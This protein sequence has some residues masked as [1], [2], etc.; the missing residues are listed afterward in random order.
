MITTQTTAT[1]GQTVIY[2][3]SM[4]DFRGPAVFL[5]PCNVDGDCRDCQDQFDLWEFHGCPGDAPI[6]YR[7][8]LAGG[9]ELA[10]VRAES[11]T[12]HTTETITADEDGLFEQIDAEGTQRCTVCGAVDSVRTEEYP[13]MYAGTER[14]ETC[15][16]CGSWEGSGD[17]FKGT[18]RIQRRH[19]IT[20]AG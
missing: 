19:R 5:G 4:T 16:G 18:R 8:R 9:F 6:R 10:C 14:T 15:D 17:P 12:A 3:G 13:S 2:H 7:I 11:F 20:A 1:E